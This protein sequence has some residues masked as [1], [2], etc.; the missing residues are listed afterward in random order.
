MQDRVE[1]LNGNFLIDSSHN[2][3]TVIIADFETNKEFYD[4]EYDYKNS[5]R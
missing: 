4:V 2:N 1:R 3:G 5:G